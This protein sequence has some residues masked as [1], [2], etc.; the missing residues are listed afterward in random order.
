[1]EDNYENSGYYPGLLV[2]L[3]NSFYTSLKNDF[4][5]NSI[6]K[7]IEKYFCTNVSYSMKLKRDNKEWNFSKKLICNV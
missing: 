3:V 7:S 6:D 2:V 1:M 4:L 5:S